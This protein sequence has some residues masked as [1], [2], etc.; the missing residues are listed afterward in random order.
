MYL[1]SE[2]FQG[3]V[4]YVGELVLTLRGARNTFS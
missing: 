1:I 3:L 4:T 2:V